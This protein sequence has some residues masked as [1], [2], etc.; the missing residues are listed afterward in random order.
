MN[1]VADI[2]SSE[3]CVASHILIGRLIL[4]LI[5]SVVAVD[6]TIYGVSRNDGTILW[7]TRLPTA[8]TPADSVPIDN[9]VFIP[10][11]IEGFVYHYDLQ[12]KKLK[13]L[14]VSLKDLV[15][16]PAFL[17][18]DGKYQT[19][20]HT[21]EVISINPFTGDIISGD[22]DA[23]SFTRNQSI[24]ITK[25]TYVMIIMKGTLKNR[26]VRDFDF[27]IEYNEFTPTETETE[28]LPG[29]SPFMEIIVGKNGVMR[30]ADS[31]R[32]WKLIFSHTVVCVLRVGERQE[33][34]F[35]LKK[36]FPKPQKIGSS[37]RLE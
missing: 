37:L 4:P 23:S 7:S 29:R 2:T 11:P 9:S 21:Q 36:V 25:T 8:Y 24:F 6:G 13:K 14:S 1:Q 27:R 16:Q 28:S 19:S 5:S 17:S 20:S 22:D 31:K 32:T 35:N 26:F 15:N 18:S 34:G 33:I 10:D 12:E 30:Y 3:E